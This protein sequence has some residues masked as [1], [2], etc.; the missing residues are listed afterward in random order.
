VKAVDVRVTYLGGSFGRRQE[1]DF[2]EEAV[3][4]SKK[5]DKPVK[6]VWT[7]E[8]DLA[9]DYYRP[10]AVCRMEAAIG[11]NDTITG[12]RH[13][14]ASTSIWK[15]VAPEYADLLFGRCLPA[16]ARWLLRQLVAKAVPLGV[17]P[18]LA[19]GAIAIPYDIPNILVDY[20]EHD[21]GIPVGAWSSVGY[22]YNLFAV[23]SFLD[24]LAA[25]LGEE[26]YELRHELLAKRPRLRVVLELA[27]SKARRSDPRHGAYTGLAV[28]EYSGTRIGMLAEI[29][30]E[31]TEAPR[32]NRIV[33]AVDC[34]TVVNPDSARAQV[35]GGIA[36]GLG[37][38]L[39]H[40]INFHDS[41]PVEQNLL[42]YELLRMDEMPEVEVYF[43]N[44][45]EPPSG[46]GEAAIP[47]VAPAVCNALY[48]A[49]G[50]RVRKLP[51]NLADF[52]RHG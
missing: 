33:C 18:N 19:E 44:S 11:R 52:R 42:Q 45:H 14:V 27:A 40:K 43:V 12:W 17:D 28:Y 21:P 31:K 16:G 4:I 22:S 36:F 23:E 38:T 41:R 3:E 48:A 10:L 24:E 30:V 5:V 1:L 50:K 34:G 32:V 15:R 20:V 13:R 49:T 35:E 37:A 51:L 8:D 9:H 46:L 29:L 2:I 25:I 26:P 39:K 47:G 7:R 6:L